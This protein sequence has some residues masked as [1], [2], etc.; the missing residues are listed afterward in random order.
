MHPLLDE[1]KYPKCAKIIAEL[2][3]CH[4]SYGRFFG[5]CNELKKQLDTCLMEDRKE[6]IKQNKHISAL[7]PSHDMKK[8]KSDH[9]EDS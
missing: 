2:A 3:E 1:K 5:K 6:K 8:Q 7:K 4:K 9:K